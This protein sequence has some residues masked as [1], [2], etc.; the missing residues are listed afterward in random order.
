MYIQLQPSTVGHACI[1]DFFEDQKKFL[2]SLANNNVFKIFKE[3][4]K[5]NINEVIQ[6]I[7]ITS[8]APLSKDAK[9]T[10]LKF[11]AID[12]K[13]KDIIYEGLVNWD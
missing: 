6:K 11:T 8:V 3:K 10:Y 7:I 12:A 2:L 13:N 1:S 9:S 5:N 4:D